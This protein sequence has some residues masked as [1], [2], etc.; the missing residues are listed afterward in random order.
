MI[1]ASS[2]VGVYVLSFPTKTR[3]T[4]KLELL[5]RKEGEMEELAIYAEGGGGY[6]PIKHMGDINQII[7]ENDGIGEQ[8]VTRQC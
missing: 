4:K 7:A 3:T 8:R 1:R 5:Y 2:N 6:I